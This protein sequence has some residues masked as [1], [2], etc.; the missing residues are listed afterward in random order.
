MSYIVV[1]YRGS[2]YVQE[3]YSDNKPMGEILNVYETEEEA[4]NI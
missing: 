2:L 1:G 3:L 4:N